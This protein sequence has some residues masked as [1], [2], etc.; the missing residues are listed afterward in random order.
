MKNETGTL[1]ECMPRHG[2]AGWWTW[3]GKMKKIKSGLVHVHHRYTYLEK[4][5]SFSGNL[6][7]NM[8]R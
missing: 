5:R 1:L 4:S 7:T 6:A 8:I 3:S 2:V